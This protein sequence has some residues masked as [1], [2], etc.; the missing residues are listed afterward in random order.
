M[1]P[2][3]IGNAA[4]AYLFSRQDLS[5]EPLLASNSQKFASLCLRG[6]A[7]RDALLTSRY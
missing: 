1:D 7:Q 4:D 5:L 3:R 2:V 6:L